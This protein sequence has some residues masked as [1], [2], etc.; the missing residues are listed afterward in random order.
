MFQIIINITEFNILILQIM[1]I[2]FNFLFD[3]LYFN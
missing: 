3:L 2:G 1:I